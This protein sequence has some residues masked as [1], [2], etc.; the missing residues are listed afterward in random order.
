[1]KVYVTSI[2]FRKLLPNN[3]KLQERL[4]EICRRMHSN[5]LPQEV[6]GE[7]L[8]EAMKVNEALIK[9]APPYI[10]QADSG[11]DGY[12]NDLHEEKFV[13]GFDELQPQQRVAYLRPVVYHN[14]YSCNVLIKGQVVPFQ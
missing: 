6:I 12:D 7:F 13:R 10:I 3:H 8:S 9:R 14:A 11:A 1:M 4:T 2:Q 5:V